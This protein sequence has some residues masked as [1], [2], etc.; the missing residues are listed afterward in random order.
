MMI[1]ARL[2]SLAC[3]AVLVSM[4]LASAGAWAETGK[5]YAL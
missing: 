1:R 4:A 2:W 5:R 3:L